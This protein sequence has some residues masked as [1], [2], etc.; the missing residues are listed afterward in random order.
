[1]HT[2]FRINTCNKQLHN[3]LTQWWNIKETFSGQFYSD[4]ILSP[5]ENS[6]MS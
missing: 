1:M 2:L 5:M 4:N 6:F 3:S